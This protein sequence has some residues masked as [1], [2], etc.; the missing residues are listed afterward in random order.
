MIQRDFSGQAYG[1]GFGGSNR[2]S[3]RAASTER[4]PAP[5]DGQPNPGGDTFR[6]AAVSSRT[7]QLVARL[8]R[9]R[10]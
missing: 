3:I 5:V 10:R 2:A 1:F 6:F 4:L 8:G 9:A 7:R